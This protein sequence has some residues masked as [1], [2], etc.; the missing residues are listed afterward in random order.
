[1][2]ACFG[3]RGLSG[4]VGQVNVHALNNDPAY[5]SDGTLADWKDVAMP[6][7]SITGLKIKSFRHWPRFA[8]HAVR[9]MAQARKAKGCLLAEARTTGTIQHTLSVWVEYKAMREF[10]MV[11]AHWD[12]M[13]D[14]R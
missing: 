1:M 2:T 4:S 7:V 9:S 3:R 14:F 12:S 8:W 5:G 10:M 13:R 11:G 6:F